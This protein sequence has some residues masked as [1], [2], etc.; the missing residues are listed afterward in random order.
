MREFLKYNF[1]TIVQIIVV[2]LLVILLVRSFTTIPDRSELLKYKLDQI[3]KN[4]DSLKKIQ[5]NLSDSLSVYKK[6]IEKIDS[7]IKNIRTEK[8]TINNYYEVKGEEI[9]G[10]NKRQIDSLLRLKY[11]Y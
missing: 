8:K 4:I 7:S 10:Y 3:D 6:Q 2:L 5:L 11:K 9:K 1:K